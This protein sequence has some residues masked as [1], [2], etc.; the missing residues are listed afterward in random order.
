M[1]KWQVRT[2]LV[3]DNQNTARHATRIPTHREIQII[4]W[5]VFSREQS[6]G[7]STKK[8]PDRRRIYRKGSVLYWQ[9][10]TVQ[11]IF[12][13]EQGAVEISS[14]FPEGKIY[15]HDILGAGHLL[16]LDDFF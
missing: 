4:I 7:R 13:I 5:H 2:P 3:P 14:L 11:S 1:G 15:I 6:D 12:V 8:W 10:G 9:G 16:G